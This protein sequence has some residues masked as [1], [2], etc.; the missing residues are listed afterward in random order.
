MHPRY[1]ACLC[2]ALLAA[3]AGCATTEDTS[4]LGTP[5][6]T[7]D[8]G[9]ALVVRLLPDGLADRTGWAIDIYAA[10][11]AL[12]IPTTRENFCAAIA[13]T[14]QES[15]LKVDPT[16]SGLPGI[17]RKEIE[18]QRERMGIPAIFLDAALA[19]PSSTGKSYGERIDTVR[20]ELQ[21]RDI[22]EDF[23]RRVPLGE[24]FLARR[25]P[26]HTGGPM[27]VSIAFATPANGS[28][29]DPARP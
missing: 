29:R 8:E 27:Q 12:E 7:A 25:N 17:A 19:L 22:Y 2:A 4:R 23:I 5:P 1:Q 9:R 10:V 24:R 20:T 11:A 21:M 14:E 3:L 26:V 16:V 28:R 6:L 18:K 13:V 15:G